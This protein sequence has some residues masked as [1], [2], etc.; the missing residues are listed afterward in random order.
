LVVPATEVTFAMIGDV[1][2]DPS[3]AVVVRFFLDKTYAVIKNTHLRVMEP[4]TEPLELCLRNPAFAASKSHSQALVGNWC[5]SGVSK[6]SCH[7]IPHHLGAY[8]HQ[9]LAY[10]HLFSI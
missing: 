9:L 1:D 6:Y 3:T 5:C 2:Y 7:F 8:P 4:K 10:I